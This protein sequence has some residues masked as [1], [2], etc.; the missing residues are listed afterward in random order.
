ME[1]PEA[2]ELVVRLIAGQTM[3]VGT[4]SVV[5]DDTELCVTYSLS[6]D[7][8]AAGW[9]IYETHLAVG[10]EV[11]DIPQTSPNLWGTNPIPGLYPYAMDFYP[12][13][14]ESHTECI[15]LEDL[16]VEPGDIVYI[17]AHA[18]V[19]IVDADGFVI[20]EETA[21]GEGNRFNARGNWGMWFE[22]EVCEDNGVVP[23]AEV[24]E[25][26]G[27]I[28]Y[29]DRLSGFDFDYN[30]FGM[31]MVLEET[32]VDGVLTNI[33]LSFVAVHNRA[34]D[35]HDIH[36]HRALQGDYSFSVFRSGEARIGNEIES[37]GY[38]GSG[39]LDVVLFDSAR[40][41]NT[42]NQVMGQW[43]V[44]EIVMDADNNLN[45]IGDFNDPVSSRWDLAHYDPK[46]FSLYD[47]WLWNRSQG[48]VRGIE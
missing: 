22:F 45:L 39:D 28:G 21:W 27:Y 20:D 46:I 18:V 29:E 23:Q 37:G 44:I 1:E 32:Y 38:T 26:D 19:M 9:R 36:I 10:T 7:A 16:G 17:S 12:D 4:V 34:G 40:W 15:L 35:V 47:P 30:D 2:C 31:D 5:K 25:F 42:A 3:D 6:D 48:N 11:A 13:G 14:V 41:S 43:I 8:L 33:F 24:I